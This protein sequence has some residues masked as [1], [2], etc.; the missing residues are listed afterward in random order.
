M[1]IISRWTVRFIVFSLVGWASTILADRSPL[2]TYERHHAISRLL[3]QPRNSTT[4][5]FGRLA[6]SPSKHASVLA[7]FLLGP[8]RAVAR[9]SGRLRVQNKVAS[10]LIGRGNDGP[11]N[12]LLQEKVSKAQGLP[13]QLKPL[14]LKIDGK[15][16][17]VTDWADKHPGGRYVLE[18][19]D[20]FDVTNAFNTI[21]LFSTKKSN[22]ILKRLPKADLGNRQSS[23]TVLPPIVQAPMKDHQPTSMDRFFKVGEKIVQLA[24]PPATNSPKAVPVVP[25]SG[26]SWQQ[27]QTND[28]LTN[29]ENDPSS[30]VV[31]GKVGDSALKQDLEDL[32]QKHFASPAE[33]KATPEHWV[34]IV[35]AFLLWA[36]CLVGWIEG[37]LPAS[38]VLPFAQWLLFSPTVHE[39]SHSTLST[40]PWVNKAAAF[41]GLPFI[42]NPYIWWRQHI[43]SH[44]QY[45]NDDALDVDL[46]HLR[47]ARLHPGSEVDE[48]YSGANFIF[49]GYFSTIGMSVL[50]PL[51]AL[52][53]KST[54]RWYE[55]LVTPKPDAVSDEEFRLSLIPIAFALIWPWIRVALG[56]INPIE[57]FFEWFYPWAV[58]GAIWTVM[59]QVSHVQ[60]DC[61]RPPTGSPDDYFRWQIESAL[62][63]SV[64]SDLVPKLTATLNL[65][66][67][68]HVMP[69]VCGCHFHKLYPEYK[70]IC[71]RHG[72]RLN[73]RKD[74][75]AAWNSC[76]ARVFELSS[77]ELTP[78]WAL[79]EP[80]AKDASLE[81]RLLEHMPLIAYLSTPAAAWLFC[82]LF[83]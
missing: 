57:G 66:S 11:I 24:S 68:H 15:W 3:E 52:Q 37:S 54:G 82:R 14:H 12:M 79:N 26:L 44:H 40:I 34:R 80:P 73:T 71:E 47:P 83:Y 41:C 61:Q 5:T 45:T 46:H 29:H 18:W 43:L 76:I 27:T 33:Y 67:M 22:E 42:Y 21:H 20:G 75:S 70:A 78:A 16:Y 32:L 49:K 2:S 39:A 60:E 31:E 38:L 56:E 50:W 36:T 69:S 53:G 7:S 74:V 10:S 55:N 58:T 65:Q 19:A 72:V 81:R 59:T 77:P 9:R 17:D 62:D 6:K 28:R 64:H 51:R 30:V 4:S 63:Y 48:G 35:G 23:P 1:A 8:H 13:D 25:A